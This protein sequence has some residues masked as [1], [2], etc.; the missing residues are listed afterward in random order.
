MTEAKGCIFNGVPSEYIDTYNHYFDLEWMKGH[1]K[2]KRKGFHVQYAKW[3]PVVFAYFM[4]GKKMRM[5]QAFAI[6]KI[7]ENPKSALCLARR[8]GK[9]T[10]V[11]LLS[12][13]MTY[14]NK[15]PKN[16][17][18]KFTVAGLVSKENDAAKKLLAAVKSLI[19]DGDVRWYNITKNTEHEEKNHFSKKLTEPTNA[20]QITWTNKSVI[21][22]FPPTKKVKGWGFSFLFIDEIAYLDPKEEDPDAFYSLTCIPTLADCGGKIC[23]ASTPAGQCYDDKTYVMT[24]DGWKLFKDI[25]KQDELL[26]KSDDGYEFYQKPFRL[27]K[28][29]YKGEMINVKS[30]QIDLS[31]TPNH[32]MW[33][34]LQ[35]GNWKFVDADY[36][37]KTKTDVWFDKGI[38]K[39]YGEDYRWKKIPS[40]TYIRGL[41]FHKEREKIIP[42]QLWYEWLGLWYADGH[43]SNNQVCITQNYGKQYDYISKITE[44]LFGRIW[45]IKYNK[46]SEGTGR[47]VINSKQ[48]ADMIRDYKKNGL[49]VS[50]KNASKKLLGLFVKGYTIGDGDERGRVFVDNHYPQMVLDIHEIFCKLGRKSN[51]YPSYSKNEIGCSTI[52]INN[53]TSHLAK[54][55]TYGKN[56]HI[57]KTQYDGMIYCATVP[58]HKLFVM[59]NGRAC[60]C[61]NSGLFYDLFDPADK[62][63]TDFFRVQFKWD[64][65]RESETYVAM[66]LA[67]KENLRRKGKEAF[68]KQEYEAEF[69]VVQSSFFD[70]ED[71]NDYFDQT[72]TDIYEWHKSPCS[73]GIDFGISIC[74]TVVTV[75]TKYNGRII[76]LYQRHFPVGFD[77]NQLMN[78]NN[79]DSIPGLLKRYDV[80]WLVPE[81]SSVSDMFVKWCK[82]EGY[83]TYAY[84]FS[85]GNLGGKNT[86]YHTYRAMLKQ[87]DLMKSYPLQLLKEEMMGLQEV[88]EKINWIISKPGSG[89][90]DCIDSDVYATTPFFMSEGSGWHG[91]SSGDIPKPDKEKPKK[92]DISTHNQRIDKGPRGM[93]IN[94]NGFIK[95]PL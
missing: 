44:E 37:T 86:A 78:P 95:S 75:K 1:F 67:E 23:I 34:K 83:P 60:W 21:K 42:A 85:G 54:C 50:T 70:V 31:V 18:E 87:P 55:R 15:Y 8:L 82:R 17:M 20:E 71:V 90:D 57:S 45:E 94:K 28:E 92:Y 77:N 32:N 11:A 39:H 38:K 41:G 51:I 27:I 93:N 35:K 48:L 12:F 43:I 59:R 65:N 89:S 80:Q 13:W 14:F 56:N 7:L 84:R 16:S 40:I 69:T 46:H 52:S 22:S 33:V 91:I 74:K 49:P 58:Y 64:I 24:Y 61:G 5:Y 10:I 62:I 19:Y 72:M 73:I 47:I 63:G 6:D 29:K 25:T 36:L 81:E 4:L 3:H 2:Q 53:K 66:V 79:E 68:F 76:T 30:K 9:S 88:Q 26:C